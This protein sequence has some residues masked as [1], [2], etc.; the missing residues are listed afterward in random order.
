MVNPTY[1]YRSRHGEDVTFDTFD[2]AKLEQHNISLSSQP[3]IAY[4][5][6][7]GRRIDCLTN[8]LNLSTIKNRGDRFSISPTFFNVNKTKKGTIVT[9]DKEPGIGE[10][11]HL[12]YDTYDVKE[13]E[14]PEMLADKLYGDSNLHWIIMYVNSITDRYHQWPL[15]T[16][17]FLAFVNDKYSNCLLYTSPSPRD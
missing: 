5:S 1:T 15:S 4:V 14:T 11:E 6:F 13:G 10:L 2:K 12:F 9:L 17:Q 7:C 16:P 3:T 8:G